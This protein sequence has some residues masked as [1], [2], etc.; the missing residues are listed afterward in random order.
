MVVHS[1]CD[2]LE[3]NIKVE[4]QS[5]MLT[6]IQDL[7]QSAGS[8]QGRVVA[9]GRHNKLSGFIK[10]E[11]FM[12]YVNERPLLSC[13]CNFVAIITAIFIPS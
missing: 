7:L 9:S 1:Y 12:D 11:G 5:V 8:G 13:Y 4:L 3:D 2:T 10:T 6:Y